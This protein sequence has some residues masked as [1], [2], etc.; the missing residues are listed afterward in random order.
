MHDHEPVGVDVG[1]KEPVEQHERVGAR[2]V[3]PERHLA[4]R[5]EVRAQLHGDG[6]ADRALDAQQDIDGPLLHIAPRDVRIAGEVVDVQLDRRGA[7]LLHG[8]GVIDPAAGRGAVEAADHGDVDGSDRALDEAEIAA[9]ADLLLGSGREVRERLGEALGAGV[10]EPRVAG[11]LASHLLLEER[12]E[13]HRA[14]AGVREAAHRVDGLGQRGGRRDQRVA[15]RQAHV[16]GREIHQRSLRASAAKC[17]AP[18][19]AISS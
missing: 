4:Q 8:A 2:L 13:D 3:E 19:V 18:W 11:L 10:D 9:G 6:H 7:G 14:D 17:S 16:V 5:A 12:V 1:L 15:E